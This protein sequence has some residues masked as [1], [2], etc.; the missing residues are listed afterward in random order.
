MMMWV[1]SFTMTTVNGKLK[2]NDRLTPQPS[3]RA[4]TVDKS[5][6][7]NCVYKI[8]VFIKSV[9]RAPLIVSR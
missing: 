2:S 3:L 6:L 9:R 1:I 5:T 7:V 4:T 8:S